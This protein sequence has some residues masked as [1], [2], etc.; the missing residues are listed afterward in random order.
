M[1]F[2]FFYFDEA[3]IFFPLLLRQNV[4]KTKIEK[5]SDS[6]NNVDDNF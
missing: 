6:S 1:H 5:K 4:F 3:C 2:I